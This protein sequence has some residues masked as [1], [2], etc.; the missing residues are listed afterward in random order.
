MESAFRDY[1]LGG[2]AIA[3][4]V[5][6]NISWGFI[7]QGQTLPRVNLSRISGGPQYSDEGEVELSEHRIQV[8]CYGSTS[9][10][11]RAI[12]DAIRARVSGENFKHSGVEFDVFI[13]DVRD[14]LDAYEGGSQEHRI[15]VDLMVWHNA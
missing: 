8:D 3:A 9:A 2:P 4:L 10:Q 12:Y 5:G 14:N 13:E 1:L 7:S 11:A 6:T 15:S